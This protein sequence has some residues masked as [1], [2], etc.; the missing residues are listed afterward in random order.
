MK[1]L[2]H[3]NREFKRANEILKRARAE[4]GRNPGIGIRRSLTLNFPV[5]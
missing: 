2:E 1:A 3:K 5:A 4:L